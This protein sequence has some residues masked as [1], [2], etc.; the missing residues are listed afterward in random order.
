MRSE[1]R[2][3]WAPDEKI[4]PCN[5]FYSMA[6]PVI[7]GLFAL[8][9]WISE[10]Q[11]AGVV[12]ASVTGG[13]LMAFKKDTFPIIP[14]LFSIIPLFRN[15][16]VF[17]DP[18]TYFMFLPAAAGLV[19]HLIRFRPVRPVSLKLALPIC[20]VGAAM[21]CGG[22]FSPYTE[23]YGAG[24]MHMVTLSVAMLAEYTFLSLYFCPAKGFAYKKYFC[25]LFI[26]IAA[27][28]GLQYIFITNGLY[29][30]GP[31][32]HKD[33]G[34][35]NYNYAGY[36]ALFAVPACYYLI[37]TANKPVLLF[38]VLLLMYAL[39][40]TVGSDGAFGIIIIFTPFCFYFTYRNLSPK[41]RR[42][43]SGMFLLAAACVAVLII[44][45]INRAEQII[46]YLKL[47]FLYDTGRTPLYEK[48]WEL[49]KSLPVFGAGIG[50]AVSIIDNGQN[51][52]SVIL[53]T[54]ATMGLVGLAAY[55]Y[56][57]WARIKILFAVN[58]PFN[59]FMY[60]AFAMFTAYSSIDCGEFTIIMVFATMLI[61][62]TEYSD[63]TYTPRLP[64]SASAK[65]RGLCQTVKSFNRQIAFFSR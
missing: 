61:A 33:L 11:F 24:I 27:V 20:S 50:Y 38:P 5:F 41:D 28:A 12:L 45:F 62:V 59:I 35:G 44:I 40:A 53:H 65:R 55:I 42:A 10:L 1:K 49:F 32:G 64:L 47:H 48:A 29:L 31:F 13:Y 19:T 7:T 23:Y 37:A 43:F 56:Y 2:I 39:P 21:F 36:L 58:T 17:S 3:K 26:S 9:F 63:K 34:W 6:Y 18:L 4:P 60:F 14:L 8:L 54:L 46:D 22:L 51:F 57:Y 25:T 52:H 30:G 16:S 15:L